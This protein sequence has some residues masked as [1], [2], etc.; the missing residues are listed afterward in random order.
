[1]DKT[2]ARKLQVYFKNASMHNLLRV[3]EIAPLT[4]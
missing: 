3:P 1:M 2:E 4:M